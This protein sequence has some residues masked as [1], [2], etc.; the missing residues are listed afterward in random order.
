LKGGKRKKK[1]EK[2]KSGWLHNQISRT[3]LHQKQ[4]AAEV[5]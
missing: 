1:Q 2:Q 5:S 3:V 4:A